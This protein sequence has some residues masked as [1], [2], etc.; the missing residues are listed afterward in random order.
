[1]GAIETQSDLFWSF[2]Q[3]NSLIFSNNLCVIYIELILDDNL[4]HV[5]HA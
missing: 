1:M 2:S 3:R 5:A 4:E